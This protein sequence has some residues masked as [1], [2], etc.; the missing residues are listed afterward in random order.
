MNTSMALDELLVLRRRSCTA[1]YSSSGPAEG[2]RILIIIFDYAN[3]VPSEGS[4]N[5][6]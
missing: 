3:T 2:A 4:D 5:G 1:K 6:A